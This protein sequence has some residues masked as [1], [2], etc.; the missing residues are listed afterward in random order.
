MSIKE[1]YGYI[2][3]LNYPDGKIYVG[4]KCSGTFQKWYFGSGTDCNR[5]KKLFGTENIKTEILEWCESQKKLQDRELFWIQELHALDPAI[6]YNRN[7]TSGT[8]GEGVAMSDLHK[9]QNRKALTGITRSEK[10]RTLIS[11]HHA[12]CS[13]EKNSMYGVHRYGKDNPNFGKKHPGLNAG[14]KMPPITEERR[15]QL[16]QQNGGSN[17]PMY[18]RVGADN[19]NFGKIRVNNGT[20]NTTIRKEDW[21]EF[22]RNGYIRGWITYKR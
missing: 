8:G 19:P 17:N 6:G 4:K 14:R 12:D 1:Y 13:G 18:G 3:K 15:A 10:T 16:R 22:A 5:L 21:E 2:Y 11:K 20:K 7:L 9:E